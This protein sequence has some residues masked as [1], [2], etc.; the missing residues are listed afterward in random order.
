[1]AAWVA[2]LDANTTLDWVVTICRELKIDD[3]IAWLDATDPRV[4]DLW[5]GHFQRKDAL[6][7]RHFEAINELTKHG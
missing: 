2:E 5:I 4:V 7:K 3:P 1:M 6:S